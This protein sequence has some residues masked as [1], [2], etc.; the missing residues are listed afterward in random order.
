MPIK[1]QRV[2]DKV[3]RKYR[4][5][6]CHVSD[7]HGGFP[8]LLGPFDVVVHS[9]DF[10]PNSIAVMNRNVTQEMAFQL[11]WLSQRL[12][13]IKQWLQ[14]RPFL[15]ILGNHDFLHPQ[16]MAQTLGSYGIKAVNLT[17]QRV[18]FGGVGFYGFPYVPTI[19]GMWNYERELPEMEVE[20]DRMV[21]EIN[22]N[23]VDVMVTH[24]PV[25]Q[26]LDLTRGNAVI[27]STVLANALDYK[28]SK[29]MKPTV[30][31]HGHCHEANGISIRNSTLISNAATTHH[32]IEIV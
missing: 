4:M 19:D 30:I 13:N 9:G 10:F 22:T 28:I 32:I 15:F 27:G 3:S 2:S 12:H 14:D 29:D 6:I 31:C 1:I 26:T 11:D 23:Y 21:K 24:A 7:T 8:K 18:E 25:Y 16:L 20:V 17:D 5:R